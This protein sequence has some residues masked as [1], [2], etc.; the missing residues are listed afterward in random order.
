MPT[1]EEAST[2]R[3]P[4]GT[5]LLVHTRIGYSKDGRPLR[6]MVTRMAADRVK[7]SYDLD[8]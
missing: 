3:M 7:I 8:A 6:Y 4:P 2:L 5:A 1:A